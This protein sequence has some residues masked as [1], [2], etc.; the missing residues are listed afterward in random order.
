MGFQCATP[1]G[2]GKREHFKSSIK[3]HQRE[4]REREHRVKHQ[5]A[6]GNNAVIIVIKMLEGFM[7]IDNLINN[8][9]VITSQ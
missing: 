9:N 1:E 2:E 8:V 6:H 4:R 7:T 3:R 5:V